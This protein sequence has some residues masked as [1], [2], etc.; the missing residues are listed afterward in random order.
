MTDFEPFSAS[1]LSDRQVRGPGISELRAFKPGLVASI[2]DSGRPTTRRR[3]HEPTQ[4]HLNGD[5]G[6][7]A[8]GPTNTGATL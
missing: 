8:A 2:P 5:P 3:R 6:Q 1:P 7:T 4:R